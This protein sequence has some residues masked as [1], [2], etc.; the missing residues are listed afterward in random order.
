MESDSNLFDKPYLDLTSNYFRYLMDK[1]KLTSF[2]V[3]SIRYFIN[4]LNSYFVYLGDYDG[5]ISYEYDSV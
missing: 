2:E 3:E 5:L 1:K 4:N